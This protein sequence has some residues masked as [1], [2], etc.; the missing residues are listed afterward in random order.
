M[1][2]LSVFGGGLWI[3]PLLTLA[4][5]V[6]FG[7]KTWRSSHSGSVTY[8]QDGSKTE[9]DKNKLNTGYLVF[10][11]ALVVATVVFII[12]MYNER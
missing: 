5:A 11:V 6:F 12:W 4:G 9:S 7:I 1:T 8:H 2:L 3:I 10:T